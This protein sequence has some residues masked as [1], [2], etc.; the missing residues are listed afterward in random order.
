MSRCGVKYN[1]QG[2][3]VEV[4]YFDATDQPVNNKEGYAK[5]TYTYDLQGNL[6]EVAFFDA[7]HQPTATARQLCQTA[8]HL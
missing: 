1:P 2:K 6:T 7:Q 3:K 8:A 4:A 5:V